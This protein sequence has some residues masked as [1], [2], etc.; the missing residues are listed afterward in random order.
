VTPLPAALAA[1]PAGATTDAPVE[2]LVRLLDDLTAV[3]MELPT[4]VYVARPA[5]RV[6][7][8]IG[9]HVRHTLD[10]IG[11][12]LA[13]DASSVLSYDHR[14]RGTAVETDPAAAVRAVLRLK[15]ALERRVSAD[16]ASPLLVES[17]VTAEGQAVEGWSTLG[18]ELAFV[19]GHTI[20]HHAIIALLLS[21]QGF[22]VPHG[23]GHAPSTPLRA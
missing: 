1:P 9:G 13:A 21:S 6:S 2:A 10:H 20:H 16:L 18:R 5:A 22:D 19:I 23:F 15:A 17:M 11:A 12:L 7:G 4:D 8:S 3:L 14:Q